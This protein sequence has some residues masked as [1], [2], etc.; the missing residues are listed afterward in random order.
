MCLSVRRPDDA[1]LI[2]WL[3]AGE[4]FAAIAALLSFARSHLGP[5]TLHAFTAPAT[6]AGVPG[7]PVGQRPVTLRALTAA[8]FTPTTGQYYLLRDLSEGPPRPDDPIAGV[9]LLNDFQG[10]RLTVI[11]ADGR[12]VATALLSRPDPE[13]GTATLWH[14]TVHPLHR[15]QGVGHR[16]L[17]QCL[18]VAAAAGA[19]RT[20]THTDPG[21]E[22][23]TRL[24][25]AHDFDIIDTIT[26]CRRHPYVSPT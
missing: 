18:H 17:T 5:R 15:R 6:R 25:S 7:L 9:T 26:V 24:L 20:A 14:L 2:H 22:P 11:G 21:D 10:W 3:H 13:S 8:G 16:L 12:E 4:D 23:T 19:R 1:G